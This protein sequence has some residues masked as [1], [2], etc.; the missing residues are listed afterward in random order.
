MTMTTADVR[1]FAYRQG[2]GRTL[3]NPPFAVD[4]DALT[5]ATLPPRAARGDRG[6]PLPCD[7]WDLLAGARYPRWPVAAAME[8]GQ[9]L[10]AAFGLQRREPS[11]AFNDH[12]VIA[13]VRSKFPVHVFLIPHRGA[14]AYLDLYRH[15]LVDLESPAVPGG[16]RPSAGSVAV[17]LAA[18]YTD[19]PTGYARLRGALTEL[20]IGVNLRSLFTAADLFG[21]PARLQ[22]ADSASEGRRL[23][24]ASGAGAWGPPVTV[25]LDG[26]AL[27]PAVALPSAGDPPAA[28]DSLLDE[29]AGHW[30]VSEAAAVAE[31]AFDLGDEAADAGHG[32]PVLANTGSAPPGGP[33]PGGPPPDAAGLEMPSWARVLWQRSAGRAP[34]GIS[35]FTVTPCQVSSS[36][37]AD[38]AAFA[39]TPA[40]S[41]RLAEAG[42]RVRVSVALQRVDGL[43]GGVYR[44]DAGELRSVR[45]DPMV[46]SAI[47]RQFGYPLTPHGA[48]GIRHSNAVWVLS[49]DVNALIT[50]LGPAGWTL[51][52]RW[53]GW[54]AHGVCTASAAHGLFARPAR[55]FD[56]HVL[57]NIMNL[58]DGQIPVFII[59]CGRTLFAEPAL[60]LRP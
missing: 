37:V 27:P 13:S 25:T 16:L 51:L 36:C 22:G 57:R 1:R 30:S 32:L 4:D 49:A 54:V 10:L 18:R 38:M 59:V 21:V 2:P 14:A 17:V 46:M 5:T 47:Q 8:P 44:L 9:V 52:Q 56:E 58:P 28:H 33:P 20:E 60:D 34:K 19:L 7:T 48:C 45:A 12:R 6:R 31:H 24:A 55:S 43:P 40:P 23:L 35:G 53:C 26:L 42:R 3:L 29:Q 41:A 39:S 15:A 50:D 11:N